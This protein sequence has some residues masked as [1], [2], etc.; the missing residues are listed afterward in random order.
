MQ[1]SGA[2]DIRA[3]LTARKQ[4]QAKL[5]DLELC[6]RGILRGFGLKLRVVTR[7]GFVARVRELVDGHPML[8]QV[9]GPML[10][11][12]DALHTQF[13]VVHK[14]MRAARA[15]G[16]GLPPADDG[17]RGRP[18][19]GPDVQVSGGRSGAVHPFQGRGAH[20]GLTPKQHRS[21]ETDV[22]GSISRAGDA[23]VRTALY[24]AANVMLSHA[25]RF[26]ALKRWAVDVVRRRGLRRAKVAL[27]RKLATVLRRIWVDGTT[28]RWSKEA[29]MAA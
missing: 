13:N 29:A 16:H 28:F 22:T 14:Q 26:S 23:M 2:Q 20:F 4:L 18:T 12:R 10:K 17:A 15:L 5:L 19:G 27:A 6:I 24:E 25:T 8:A 11:A 3:L 7:S 1:N 9:V 21:D